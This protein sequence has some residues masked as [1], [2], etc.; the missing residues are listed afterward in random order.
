MRKKKP[1][2]EIVPLKYYDQWLSFA[3]LYYICSRLINFV[4]KSGHYFIQILCKITI[5]SQICKFQNVHI[6]SCVQLPKNNNYKQVL[7]NKRMIKVN[8]SFLTKFSF[9]FVTFKNPSNCGTLM[10]P[11]LMHRK[12]N[13]KMFAL[14]MSLC[15]CVHAMEKRHVLF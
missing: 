7:R 1:H 9:T 6:L 15:T 8:Q 10:L 14:V 12:R 13:T 11:L 4:H 3:V 2:F 5:F